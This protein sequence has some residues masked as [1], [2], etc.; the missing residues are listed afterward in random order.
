MYVEGLRTIPVLLIDQERAVK[1]VRF[2]SPVYIGDPINTTRLWSE[3]CVDEIICLDIS[4][5][6]VQLDCRLEQIRSIVDESFVPLAYGGGV[7]TLGDAEKIFRLGVERVIVGWN[8]SCSCE[9]IKDIAGRYGRQAVSCCIDYSRERKLSVRLM[10]KGKYIVPQ[11]Q[12]FSAMVD[13]VASGAGEV[14]LQCVDRDGMM[15]GLDPMIK[16]VANKFT[17][18]VVL[19]GGTGDLSDVREIHEHGLSVASGSLFVYFNRERQVLVGNP[20]MEQTAETL[21]PVLPHVS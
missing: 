2:S 14:I 16:N 6:R 11:E 17:T 18:P 4:Q 10:R 20:L 7:N 15:E 12:V 8:G 3:M 5:T 1:T 13:A 9:I 19:L 21:E